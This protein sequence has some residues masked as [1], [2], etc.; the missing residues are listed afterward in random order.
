MCVSCDGKEG[1][2]TAGKHSETHALVQC[3]RNPL[4]ADSERAELHALKEK[5]SSLDERVQHM[6]S[7]LRSPAKATRALGARAV[8]S[9]QE[10]VHA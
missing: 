9:V 10:C 8:A 7:F 1:G 4:D 5:V 3:H 2:I 6:D